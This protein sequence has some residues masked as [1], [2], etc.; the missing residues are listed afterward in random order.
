MACVGDSVLTTW[1]SAD[2]SSDAAEN[3]GTTSPTYTQ[4]FKIPNNA[5]VCGSSFYG[6]KGTVGTQPG[7][8]KI[9]I[10]DGISGTVLTTTG[11]VSTSGMADYTTPDWYKV[12]FTS[13]VALTAGVQYYM[14]MTSLTG[15]TNDVF[16]WFRDNAGST[17][18]D[19]VAYVGTTEQVGK[20]NNF[21]VHGVEGAP[22]TNSN[23]FAIM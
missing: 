23:F 19:G 18:T 1:E 4:S 20:D 6:G 11:S 5:D 2:P 17:Y 22:A 8:F 10:L 12:D 7:T 13:V 3:N 16:R 15:S 9:E 14:K 21:R